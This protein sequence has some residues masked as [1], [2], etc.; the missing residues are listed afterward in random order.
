MKKEELSK[1]TCNE[2][3]LI[4]KELN[5]V[6]RSKMTKGQLVEAIELVD[7][8]LTTS[9]DNVGDECKAEGH[10]ENV[11]QEAQIDMESRKEYVRNA[12]K[13]TIMAFKLPDGRVKS[14]KMVERSLK[15]ERLK[16]ET[17]Y[18]KQYTIDFKDVIWVKTGG[19]WPKGVFN[20]LKR[21]AKNEKSLQSQG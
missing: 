3:R 15:R 10:V 5:I 7:V 19:R 20:L 9:D 17:A 21:N 8:I 1:K 13:G 18:G 12:E 4:A 11:N 16:M 6:G 14:A 2:L